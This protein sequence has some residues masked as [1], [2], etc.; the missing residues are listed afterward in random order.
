[1]K[2]CVLGNLCPE[3]VEEAIAMVPSIRVSLLCSNLF[4]SF[5][6]LHL[7]VTWFFFS[8][9]IKHTFLLDI[10]LLTEI[11]GHKRRNSTLYYIFVRIVMFVSK[12]MIRIFA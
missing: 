7:L 11:V 1:M 6:K 8:F 2:L 5:I 4:M 12:K 9:L 3:T 10:I